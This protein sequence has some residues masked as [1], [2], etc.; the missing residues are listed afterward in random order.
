MVLTWEK[1]IAQEEVYAEQ[2]CRETRH[3]R[4]PETFIEL[5]EGECHV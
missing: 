4:L 5:E 3:K 1:H 2:R